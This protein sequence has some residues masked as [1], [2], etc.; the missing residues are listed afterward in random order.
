MFL[1]FQQNL[2]LCLSWVRFC[3]CSHFPVCWWTHQWDVCSPV[4]KSKNFNH[5]SQGNSGGCC[6][7]ASE[8]SGITMSERFLTQRTEHKA[9]QFWLYSGKWHQLPFHMATNNVCIIIHT[10]SS[11]TPPFH[12]TLF[13]ND[14]FLS[15]HK[16]IPITKTISA[17]EDY[18][19]HK[20]NLSNRG[21]FP[22]QKQSQQQRTIPITKTISATED[23][24]VL[25]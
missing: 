14:C 6:T 10:C 23:C 8:D 11:H 25:R 9:L 18:S 17:T 24:E 2:T 22:S 15:V 16:I 3:T 13:N 12:P 4:F 20:N 21:L 1:F 5:P 7:P 19:H